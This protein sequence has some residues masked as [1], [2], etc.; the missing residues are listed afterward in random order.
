[1]DKENRQVT[2]EA[3]APGKSEKMSTLKKSTPTREKT[4]D[5]EK[6]AERDIIIDD[7]EGRL[8]NLFVDVNDMP[9]PEDTVPKPV[10]VS[11]DKEKGKDKLKITDVVISKKGGDVPA[12]PQ[13]PVPISIDEEKIKKA[14]KKSGISVREKKVALDSRPLK[15][16]AH[17]PNKA[18]KAE[19]GEKAGSNQRIDEKKATD[20]KNVPKTNKEYEKNPVEPVALDESSISDI[21]SIENFDIIASKKSQK[22]LY[23]NKFV[24]G[25]ILVVLVVVS[26]IIF[27]PF[28]GVEGDKRRKSVTVRKIDQSPEKIQAKTVNSPSDTMIAKE[29]E[30]VVHRDTAP[31]QDIPEAKETAPLIEKKKDMLKAPAVSYPYSIHAG[32]YRSSQSAELSAETYRNTDL[33]AFWVRVDLGEKGVWYRVFI[34]CYKDPAMAQEIIKEKRLKDARPIRVRYVNFIGTYLSNDDLKKQSRFL[35][36]RGYS[37]YFIQDD[38]GNNYLYTGAFDTLKEAEIFSVE[39]SSKGIRSLVVE[40]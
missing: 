6:N 37:P 10:A 12:K 34:E 2:K 9:V 19:K 18:S 31:L 33:Q 35:S 27:K 25:G 23:Q 17:P 38:N 32:S 22:R 13:P 8:D 28:A 16:A 5:G 11:S 14:F 36:E 7:L 39:L 3:D 15:T 1:M 21:E 26:F 30:P 20:S 29:A 4:D 40:R 24:L